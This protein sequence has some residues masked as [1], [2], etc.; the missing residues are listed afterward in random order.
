MVL[1]YS[2]EDFDFLI[3]RSLRYL[4]DYRKDFKSV[5]E[6]EIVYLYSLLKNHLDTAIED[7]KINEIINIYLPLD[8][9]VFEKYKDYGDRSLLISGLFREYYLNNKTKSGK[10]RNI[11]AL[12]IHGR[13]AYYKAYEVSGYNIFDK[14][15]RDFITLSYLLYNLKYALQEKNTI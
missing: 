9:E 14:L 8:A 11:D 12:V 1:P 13:V 6:E 10:L 15:S 4:K 7:L 5:D 2:I 3:Y